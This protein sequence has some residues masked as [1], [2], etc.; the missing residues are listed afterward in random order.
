[1]PLAL[2]LCCLLGY[3][4]DSFAS[5]ARNTISAGHPDSPQ[6][7][8]TSCLLDHLKVDPMDCNPDGSYSLLLDVEV[9]DPDIEEVDVYSNDVLIGT[10]DKK[11][12]PLSVLAFEPSG[13][14]YDNITVCAKDSDTCCISKSFL[15]PLCA[16]PCKIENVQ[17]IPT[18]CSVEGQFY[19]NLIFDYAQV[20]NAGFRVR[21]N[22]SEYG[23]FDWD[24]LPVTLGPFNGDRETD[25]TFYIS[26]VESGLCSASTV[27]S[28][29]DCYKV[30][31]HCF[32]FAEL[33]DS[34]SFGKP[35]QLPGSIITEEADVS[36][37]M[38]SVFLESGNTQF[39]S[40][41]YAPEAFADILGFSQAEGSFFLFG[42]SSLKF[43][44]QKRS[45]EIVSF[46]F[47]YIEGDE[48]ENISVNG[49]VAQVVSELS[50]LPQTLAPEASIQI[51][52]NPQNEEEGT[53]I[54]TG[55]IDEVIIGGSFGFGIDN[56]CMQTAPVFV[57]VWPGDTNSDGIANNLDLLNIGVAFG[58]DGTPRA[59]ENITW[60]GFPA[61]EWDERFI[62]TINYKHADANGDGIVDTNDQLAVD[63][64]YGKVHDSPA[65]EY[66]SEGDPEDPFLYVDLQ[67]M[68]G[69]LP[70]D[71]FEAPI[72]LGSPNKPIEEIYGVAFT[73]NY[74]GGVLDPNQV[75]IEF[76]PSW[77]GTPG[78]DLL[79]LKKKFPGR[80]EVALVR[81]DHENVGGFGEI[82]AFV[83][84][85]D[86]I[87]GRAEVSVEIDDIKGITESEAIVKLFGP[88]KNLE[89][90][91]ELE[92][93]SNTLSYGVEI[94][95][96]PVVDQVTF[97][98]QGPEEV[99]RLA[100]YDGLGN[101]L[102]NVNNPDFWSRY[103]VKSWPSGIY[104]MEAIIDGRRVTKRFMVYKP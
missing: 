10:F 51:I 11:H 81:S 1:M 88:A 53:I 2:L 103:K 68:V 43:E 78:Q 66:P 104:F 55:S 60:K 87:A 93:G 94:F 33:P 3:Q 31:N 69:I 17:A 75:D 95:P 23:Q 64:N 90:V 54:I 34:V 32:E 28:A 92:G 6:Q 101:R 45:T 91:A 8:L 67:D 48:F 79:V 52:P 63:E 102:L 29:V 47:D 40:L 73:I 100:I 9:N 44:F 15:P 24:E 56:I 27:L 18:P 25:Y 97:R 59:S 71:S 13:S 72:V 21:G 38:E 96:N 83:G 74:T 86:N 58:F 36:I 80:I 89:V 5:S 49:S 41:Q 85:I 57:E 16:Q 20:G 39:G 7:T 22:D 84:I 37:T 19:V 50:L 30:V 70:G 82:S 12:L 35:N 61:E 77:L 42:R 76:T 62:N 14:T 98:Y 4:L 65:P 46:S 26:D 99:E